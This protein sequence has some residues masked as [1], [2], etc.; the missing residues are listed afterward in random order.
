MPKTSISISKTILWRGAQEEFSNVYTYDGPTPDV[1]LAE[2]LINAIS[3]AERAIFANTVTFKQG[4]AWTAGGTPAQNETILIKDLSGP[5]SNQSGGQMNAEQCYLVEWKTARPS[6]TGKPVRLKKFL[7]TG[8]ALGTDGTLVLMNEAKI[9]QAAIDI[10]K[11]YMVKV[12]QPQVPGGPWR[13]ASL[14]DRIFQ[15]QL[16]FPWI[17]HREFT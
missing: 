12:E 11:A 2:S 14:S 9:S 8:K 13:L 1:A 6:A 5:G 7:H 3:D 4:R 16:V 10:L 17:E 15:S